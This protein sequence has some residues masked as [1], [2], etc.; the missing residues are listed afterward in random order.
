MITNSRTTG[1]KVESSKGDKCVSMVKWTPG[2]FLLLLWL[3]APVIEK[4]PADG[5]LGHD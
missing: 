5:A 4:V 1:Q 3:F 2:L